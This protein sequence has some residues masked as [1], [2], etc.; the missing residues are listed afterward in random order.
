MRRIA[1]AQVCHPL[2][3]KRLR[4]ELAGECDDLVLGEGVAAHLLA[5][6]DLE[7]LP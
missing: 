5:R 1:T 7:I 3:V 4:V 2:G 6:A